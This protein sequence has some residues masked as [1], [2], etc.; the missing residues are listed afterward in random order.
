MRS[1]HFKN[2]HLSYAKLWQTNEE[3]NPER[4]LRNANDFFL[5][6]STELNHEQKDASV[7]FL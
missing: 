1:Y 2:F 5:H 7:I 6:H 4:V 3:R